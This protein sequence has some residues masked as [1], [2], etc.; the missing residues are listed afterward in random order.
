MKIRGGSKS[1]QNS[2]LRLRRSKKSI[3]NSSRESLMKNYSDIKQNLS[4]YRKLVRSGNWSKN[5]MRSSIKKSN[6]Q[7]LCIWSTKRSTSKSLSRKSS[8]SKRKHWK[9][10]EISSTKFRQAVSKKLSASMRSITSW[11][12]KR[13][14]PRLPKREKKRSKSSK[15]I[16][17]R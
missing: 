2:Y 4:K 9:T 16:S 8:R 13:K 1:W 14:R 6:K 10:S 3:K 12:S 11:W 7:N 15:N 17:D 5:K